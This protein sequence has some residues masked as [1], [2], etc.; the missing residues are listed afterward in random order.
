[1]VK[2]ERKQPCC[3]AQIHFFCRGLEMPPCRLPSVM[4][5]DYSFVFA[6]V[7]SL[8]R[9]EWNCPLAVAALHMG[10]KVL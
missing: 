6:C 7:L 8:R 1:M 3:S 9:L 5:G 10:F 2:G 4:R